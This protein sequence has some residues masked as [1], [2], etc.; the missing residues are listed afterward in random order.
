MNGVRGVVG[1]VGV[2]VFDEYLNLLPLI[3]VTRLFIQLT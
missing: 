3:S 2:V 1:V